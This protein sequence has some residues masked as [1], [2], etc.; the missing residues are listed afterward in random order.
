MNEQTEL[1]YNVTDK[2]QAEI[3]GKIKM[4]VR[5]C[6]KWKDIDSPGTFMLIN[7]TDLAIDLRYQREANSR[8]R[9]LNIAREF[10][11]PA[12]G[13]VIV[14]MRPDGFFVIDGGH[15]V[16]ASELRDDIV[17]V[18]C[19]V[20]EFETAEDEALAFVVLNS[21]SKNVSPYHKFKAKLFA[22]DPLAV[23]VQK[24]MI[25]KNY[26]FVPYAKSGRTT[27]AV[28]AMM[29]AAAKD[30]TAFSVAL[31]L[32]V[33]IADGDPLPASVF[34]GLFYLITHDCE[35]IATNTFRKKLIYEG[36]DKLSRE[37]YRNKHLHE[38]GGVL[39]EAKTILN[40][41]NKGRRTNKLKL[42]QEEDE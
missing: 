21:T 22:G 31:D 16:R 1:T 41:V 35:A 17:R 18:P 8:D 19:M 38:A 37:I 42:K 28:A 27:S 3:F 20:Y 5:E 29:L 2:S 14:S 26:E 10:S 7:K 13:T 6:R 9:I 12:F 36:I 25:D 34:R 24:L 23:R 33:E 39:I 4:P 30:M 11:W 40:I 15:R 32:L